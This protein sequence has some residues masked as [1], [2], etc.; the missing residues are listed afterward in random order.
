MHKFICQTPQDKCTGGRKSMNNSWKFRG[1][2]KSSK[3]HNSP[4][5]AFKCYADYLESIGYERLGSREFRRPEGGIEILTKSSRYGGR[6]R[7]GKN[8]LK[9][10]QVSRF[11]PDSKA[12]TTR[13]GMVIG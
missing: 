11:M 5:E 10:T 13:A 9:G 3:M 12:K 8:E 4:Q 2:D 1:G 6:L 7:A